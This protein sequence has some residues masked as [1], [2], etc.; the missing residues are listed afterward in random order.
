MHLAQE[1]IVVLEVFDPFSRDGRVKAM[2]GPGQRAVQV[3]LLKVR[4]EVGGRFRIDVRA[5]GLQTA[6][7]KRQSQ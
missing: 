5:D 3:Y 1:R 2:V 6:L 4:P 7:S